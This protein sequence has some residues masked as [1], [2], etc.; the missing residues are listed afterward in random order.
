[1]QKL[2]VRIEYI[3]N[4]H[5]IKKGDYERIIAGERIPDTK[6]KAYNKEYEEDGIHIEPIKGAFSGSM[7]FLDF[8]ERINGSNLES[9]YVAWMGVEHPYRMR[10][11]GTKLVEEV[12]R[13][14][15]ERGAKSTWG[16]I[17][18]KRS[19]RILP[20]FKKLG[21]GIGIVTVNDFLIFKYL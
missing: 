17:E 20:F 18:K 13:V 2:P 21:Y 6:R 8:N 19:D 16:H 1:M 3:G 4:I 9:I 15:I 5:H 7:G 14:A 11:V 12:E 10:G